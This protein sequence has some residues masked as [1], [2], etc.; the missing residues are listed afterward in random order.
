MEKQCK[1]EKKTCPRCGNSFE[2]KVGD[3][4]NCQCHG[5]KFTNDMMSF[6][7]KHYDD[8]LCRGCLMELNGERVVNKSIVNGE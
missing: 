7:S 3:I 6:V 5:I 1:H 2:C 8:C 4:V